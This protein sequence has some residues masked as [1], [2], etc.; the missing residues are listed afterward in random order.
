[1]TLRR[2]TLARR[3]T[4]IRAEATESALG[5]ETEATAVHAFSLNRG[6]RSSAFGKFRAE[7]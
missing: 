2:V 3:K 7:A 4:R 1:M 5:S 6:R